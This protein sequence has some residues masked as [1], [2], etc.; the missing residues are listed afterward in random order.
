MIGVVGNNVMRILR[1]VLCPKEQLT[2]ETDLA[3]IPKRECQKALF[4]PFQ[5]RVSYY[6]S[7]NSLAAA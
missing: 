2:A 5:Y 6:H 1:S 3:L 7:Y 4:Y